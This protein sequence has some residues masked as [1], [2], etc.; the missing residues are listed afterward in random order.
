MTPLLIRASV[1]T[2]VEAFHA[3]YAHS[4]INETATFEYLPPTH[5]EFALRRM[6]I[7]QAGYS[8]LAAERDGRVVGYAYTSAFRARVGYRF[9]VEDSIYIAPDCKGQGIGKQLLAALIAESIA[10]GFHQMIAV[11][12]DATHTASI[13]LHAGSGFVPVARYE[14]IGFKFGRWLDSV[15]MQRSLAPAIDVNTAKAQ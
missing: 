12:G 1:D 8:Y 13:Q 5:E 2:D 14:A 11:I 15:H 3:I 9:T 7:L 4:V 6:A 10:S